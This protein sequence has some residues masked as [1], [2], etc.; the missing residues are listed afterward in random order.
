MKEKIHYS[1]VFEAVEKAV[2]ANAVQLQCSECGKGFYKITMVGIDEPDYIIEEGQTYK[3]SDHATYDLLVNP[4]I[5]Q[6]III[7]TNKFVSSRCKK[8][9]VH[10]KSVDAQLFIPNRYN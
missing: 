2:E 8:T 5:T 7:G 6:P 4:E 3:C 1:E 10:V 9:Q